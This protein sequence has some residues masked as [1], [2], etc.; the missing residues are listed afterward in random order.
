MRKKT[1]LS[2][3]KITSQRCL[4]QIVA[5]SMH[6]LKKNSGGLKQSILLL[7]NKLCL[8]NKALL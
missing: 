3:V 7:I 6:P 2:F 1:P 5:D 4:F 8:L